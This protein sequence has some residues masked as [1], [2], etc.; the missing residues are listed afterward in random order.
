MNSKRKR[1]SARALISL[2][3]VSLFIFASAGAEVAF[4]PTTLSTS[5]SATSIWTNSNSY[6][7]FYSVQLQTTGAIGSGVEATFIVTMPPGIPLSS[8]FRISWRVLT[9]TGYPPHIDIFLSSGNVLTAEMAYNNFMSYG[10]LQIASALPGYWTETFELTI[11][12]GFDDIQS[13]TIFWVANM[14]AGTWDSPSGTLMQWMTNSGTVAGLGDPLET[15]PNVSSD[16]IIKIEFEV[17]NWVA[18]S[19]SYIDDILINGINVMGLPGPTGATGA[20]GP[21]GPVGPTGPKGDTGD[22]GPQGPT[23][24]QGDTGDEGPQGTEGDQGDTGPRGPEGRKGDTGS[25]GNV[26]ATGQDGSIGSEGPQGEQGLTG[27]Q[28]EQGESGNAS[29][30]GQIGPV[31]PKGSSGETGVKGDPGEKGDEGAQG[32]QGEIG[33]EGIVPVWASYGIIL[34]AISLIGVAFL[35]VMENMR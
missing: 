22:V 35:F 4:P 11:G 18:Q 21:T 24:P 33:Q 1:L 6:T 5:G 27:L 10:I 28:G 9:T 3:I 25:R 29:E 13:N 14:G 16:T 8:L 7:G 2:V 19:D 34:G 26:G 30:Q 20:T 23:G 32:P 17:D 31:G 12:D 15:V